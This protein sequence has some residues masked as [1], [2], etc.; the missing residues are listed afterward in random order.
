MRVLMSMTLTGVV[1]WP[2]MAAEVSCPI[3]IPR[4]TVAEYHRPY[5]AVWLETRGPELS[6]AISRSGTTSSS[7]T[8]KAPSG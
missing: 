7:R 1:A 4:L 6:S 5:V 2:A 3:E 8:T